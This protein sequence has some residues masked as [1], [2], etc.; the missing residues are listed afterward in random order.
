MSEIAGQNIIFLDID[1]VLVLK[2][3]GE[4]NSKTEFDPEAM[5]WVVKLARTAFALIVVS[6]SWRHDNNLEETKD[7]MGTYGASDELLELIVDQTPDL[8]TKYSLQP[9]TG[10]RQKKKRGQEIADW[11]MEHKADNREYVIIDDVK[12]K[13][14]SKQLSHLVQ[15]DPEVG[16]TEENY[17]QGMQILQAT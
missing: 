2:G 12:D 13:F 3:G 11:L 9:R 14:F 15:T 8:T 7:L 17:E 10:D 5:E 6:S 4:N 16:F 1:G